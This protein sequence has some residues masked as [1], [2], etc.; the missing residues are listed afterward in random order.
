M[1]ALEW[2][3]CVSP[4]RKSPVVR[5]VLPQ[6]PSRWKVTVLTTTPHRYAAQTP[7]QSKPNVPAKHPIANVFH[8]LRLIISTLLEMLSTRFW[9]QSQQH[10]WDLA[11]MSEEEAWHSLTLPLHPKGVRWNWSLGS[12]PTHRADM[13]QGSLGVQG[14]RHAGT[15]LC[16]LVPVKAN[17]K[18]TSYKVTIQNCDMSLGK[19]H[20]WVHLWL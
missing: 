8:P 11:L 17:L 5:Q 1:K 12:V 19:T 13:S 2:L 7:D 15:V 20:I 6:K 10:W 9:I 3:A 4:R 18:A 14:H 16:L